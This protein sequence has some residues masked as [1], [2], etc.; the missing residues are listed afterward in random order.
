MWHDHI[1]SV[2]EVRFGHLEAEVAREL[3]QRPISDFPQE[4][5]PNDVAVQIV[6]RTGGRPYL[7]PS[8]HAASELFPVLCWG[9]LVPPAPPAAARIRAS[10][11][12]DALG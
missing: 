2:R 5:M 12:G 1:V 3:V 8:S 6:E 7:V 4:T 10:T 11:H 9:M